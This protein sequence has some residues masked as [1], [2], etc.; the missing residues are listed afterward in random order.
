MTTQT[1]PQAVTSH[2]LWIGN[3]VLTIA[4]DTDTRAFP[5]HAKQADGLNNIIQLLARA[6][7]S[8]TFHAENL[9]GGDAEFLV[10]PVEGIADAI[11]LLSQLSDAVN[12]RIRKG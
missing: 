11:V 5:P 9:E 1:E 12:S 6:S 3:D 10:Q 4:L 2:D 8:V 7:K